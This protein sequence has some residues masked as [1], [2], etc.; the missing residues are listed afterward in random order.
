MK[1]VIPIGN[2][3]LQITI[4]ALSVVAGTLLPFPEFISI[5]FMLF[6]VVNV[7]QIVLF[8]RSKLYWM[9]VLSVYF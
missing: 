3:W 8:T 4:V 5:G 7:L 6:C 1:R 2:K 9:S